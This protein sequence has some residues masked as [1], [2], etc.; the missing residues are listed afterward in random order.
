MSMLSQ[1]TVFPLAGQSKKQTAVSHSTPEAEIVAA[2]HAIR[3][4]GIPQLVLWETLLGRPLV[5]HFHED[6]ET[7]IQ[8]CK[9]GRSA[10]L[11]HV[12]RTHRVSIKWLHEMFQGDDY[13][14][15]YEMT[16]RQ[17]ADIFT[18]DFTDPDK[19]LHGGSMPAG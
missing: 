8:I 12:G 14:L 9:T 7:C 11:R 18:T 19:W 10:A 17:C 2:D 5:V 1:N 16:E 6:N 4:E 13:K 3:A 15:F